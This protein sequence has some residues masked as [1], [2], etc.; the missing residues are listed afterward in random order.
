MVQVLHWCYDRA[1]EG[2]PYAGSA[3]ELGNDYLAMRGTLEQKINRLIRFQNKK[4]ATSGFVNG[5][6]GIVLMPVT[7]PASIVSVMYVQ[8]RMIAAIAHMCGFD[9]RHDSVRTLCYICL[10]GNAGADLV[11]GVGTK[12]GN[13]MGVAAVKSIPGKMLIQINK[14][15]GFRLLKK[16]GSRGV[17]NLSKAVPIL[18]GVIGAAFDGVSTNTVGNVA[19]DTF[20]AGPAPDPG[21]A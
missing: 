8:L 7:L 5:L 13:K 3:E 11:K 14:R 2:L 20:I 12:L 15:V 21:A 4:A 16:V 6:G 17:V 1:I 9:V 18:G 10:C 19:R